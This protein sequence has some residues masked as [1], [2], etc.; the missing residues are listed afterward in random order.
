MILY[1]LLGEY[2]DENGIPVEGATVIVNRR[3]DGE[4]LAVTETD[5]EGLFEVLGLESNGLVYVSVFQDGF[6]P[7][8]FDQVEPEDYEPFFSLLLESGDDLLTELGSFISLEE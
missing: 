2:L 6:V 4:P 5:A 8:I 1:R 3:S 7:Q